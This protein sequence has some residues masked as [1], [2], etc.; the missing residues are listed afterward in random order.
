MPS[1]RSATYASAT[2]RRAIPAQARGLL[3]R[4]YVSAAAVPDSQ[5]SHRLEGSLAHTPHS[6]HRADSPRVYSATMVLLYHRPCH[7]TAKSGTSALVR[8]T[9]SRWLETALFT[10]MAV[11]PH[12]P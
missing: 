2:E 3:Y 10:A 11:N 9:R 4:A 5:H 6:S 8:L 7:M 1:V 12:S